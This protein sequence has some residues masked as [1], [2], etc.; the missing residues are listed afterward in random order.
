MFEAETVRDF[1]RAQILRAAREV[2]SAG[3]LQALTYAR[4]ESKLAF[5]RG[6]ITHHF[7]NK[8][9]IVEAMLRSAVRE[10]DQATLQ[11]VTET[12]DAE[13]RLRRTI[14]YNVN[15]FL[16]RRDS[17][18]VL[19]SFVGQAQRD[20]QI[21]A[22]T[23]SFLARWRR[24]TAAMLQAGVS[25][26]TFRVHDSEALAAVMVGQIL[27]IVVQELT[28]PGSIEVERSVEAACDAYL[29]G[30]RERVA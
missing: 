20:P 9:E 27:G 2:V 28:A 12:Q 6:V 10:I 25:E 3:G 19:I 17:A 24:W 15:G 29:Y 1:R 26:G 22:F 18:K 30:V 13:E 4:L 5:T 23:D 16:D 11:A 7:R 8:A 21:A 14:A